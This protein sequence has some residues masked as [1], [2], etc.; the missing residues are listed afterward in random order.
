MLRTH[1]CGKL[2][3]KDINKQVTLCGWIQR[4][5]DLGGMRVPTL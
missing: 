1:T 2:C 5:R 4:S 3:L